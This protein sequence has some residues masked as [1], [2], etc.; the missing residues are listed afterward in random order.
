MTDKFDLNDKKIIIQACVTGF[1]S[2]IL[3]MIGPIQF[4]GGIMYVIDTVLFGMASS[5]ANFTITCLT[6]TC[7]IC[8]FYL[9]WKLSFSI[10]MTESSTVISIKV[11][12]PKK[13]VKQNLTRRN[14]KESP[15][16]S[17]NRKNKSDTR[18]FSSLQ[19]NG[20]DLYMDR[21]L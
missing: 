4:I 11:I 3:F 5:I 20:P 18:Q 9:S 21:P 8:M 6:I 15:R 10:D 12:H 7:L 2:I 16:N 14:S 1:T 17:P 13:I 19:Y